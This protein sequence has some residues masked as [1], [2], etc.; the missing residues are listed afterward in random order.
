MHPDPFLDDRL[1]A[2]NDL[3]VDAVNRALAEDRDDLVVRLAAEYED[4][5]L[6]LMS[7]GE[8]PYAA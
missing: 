2:L 1:H 4:D 5:A 7:G 6:V 8:L 3:Y